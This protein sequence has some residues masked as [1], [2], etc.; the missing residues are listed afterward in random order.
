MTTTPNQNPA[1]VRTERGLTIA[2]TRISIYNVMDFVKAQ[3]PSKLIQDR[4]NLTDAQVNAALSYIEANRAQV[5]AEYQEVLRTREEI[6]RYW[7]EQNREH[8]AQFATKPH[9]PE[10]EALWAKLEEQK[11][12]RASMN[13]LVDYN[14]DGYAAV[15]LGF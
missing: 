9:K 10:Q 5:E 14:L 12:E 1:V 7:E 11:A 2:G 13:F 15:L 8:F 4:F 6:H 3:Y